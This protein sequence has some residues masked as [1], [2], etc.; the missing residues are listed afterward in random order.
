M[1][2]QNFLLLNWWVIGALQEA[3]LPKLT[4]LYD[5][6]RDIEVDMCVVLAVKKKKYS[7]C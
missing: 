2:L 7:L 4:C 6:Q 5:W 3:G 1:Q